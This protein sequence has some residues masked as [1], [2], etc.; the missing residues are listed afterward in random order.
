MDKAIVLHE[1]FILKSL[2][3]VEALPQAEKLYIYHTKMVANFQAERL[4]HLI[5][6]M[7]F[8]LFGL[9]SCMALLLSTN[10]TFVWLSLLFM[11]LL[12]PYIF[13]YYKLENG[14]QRLYKLDKLILE[15][16][17]EFE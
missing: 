1:K 17:E 6:T 7:F 13:H 2:N 11:V 8:G 9:V 3:Y 14:V 12:I 10:T 4:V 5:V 16:L 15:R